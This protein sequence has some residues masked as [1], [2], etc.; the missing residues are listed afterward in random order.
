MEWELK[1]PSIY[2]KLQRLK[3]FSFQLHLLGE[4]R[5]EIKFFYF[6]KTVYTYENFIT[7]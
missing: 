7:C 5:S 4:K 2:E 1:P 6:E 3:Y